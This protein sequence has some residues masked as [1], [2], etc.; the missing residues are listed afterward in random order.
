ME[1]QAG[2][3]GARI[4]ITAARKA[5]EQARMVADLGG[6][7]IVGPTLQTVPLAD[8]PE[9]RS[10]VQDVVSEPPDVAVLITG[11][12]TRGLVQAATSLGMREAVL[13]SLEGAR[14]FARGPKARAALRELGLDVEWAPPSETSAELLAHLRT[15]VTPGSRVMVQAHGEPM[16]AFRDA[17]A[18]RGATVVE[19]PVYRWRPPTDPT[20]AR[21]LVREVVAARVDAVSFT[22]AP[23]VRGLF[24]IAGT[25]GAE[26]DLRRHLRTCI[27]ASV[28]DVTTEALVEAGVDADFV[29]SRPRMGVM[30]RE[31][32][33]RWSELVTSRR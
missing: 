21:T 10:A 24:A 16:P 33:G 20:P 7:P 4:G 1:T 13:A 6:V 22:S 23:S 14:R 31:L 25:F 30:Y 11:V 29:P 8:D 26:G 18:A 12:G 15:V 32:A 17:L 3:G 27:L 5:E 28:G 19:V 9:V 2:F